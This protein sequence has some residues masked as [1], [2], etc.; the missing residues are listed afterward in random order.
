M[1]ILR[2]PSPPRRLAL[3]VVVALIVAGSQLGMLW[4]ANAYLDAERG[5]DVLSIEAL[6]GLAAILLALLSSRV[7]PRPRLPLPVAQDQVGR[8]LF[9]FLAVCI[10]GQLLRPDRPF[11]HLATF[12]SIGAYYVIGTYVG[13]WFASER[14]TLPVLPILLATYSLWYLGLAVFYAQGDLGFYG[15]LPDSDVLRLE[16]R[17]GFT[18]TE[19]PIYVGFQVPVLLYAL[20]VP[21]GALLTSWALV[22]LACAATLVYLS[23]SSAA[24][25]AFLLVCVV[26]VMARRGASLSSFLRVATVGGAAVAV[27][28][29]VAGGV[30][31]SVGGKLLDFFSNDGVRARIYGEL[32]AI[33]QSQPMGIGKSRFVNQNDFGLSGEGVFP[34]NN[35]LGI[36]AEMGVLAMLLFLA[37]CAAVLV[38]LGRMAWVRRDDIPARVRMLVAIALG[39]FL[40]QQFRGLFQ[41]TWEVK[42]TYFWLGVGAGVGLA[43]ARGRGLSPAVRPAR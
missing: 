39:T 3:A 2:R 17:G 41:D 43:F 30:V 15:I 24:M 19:V 10:A 11:E 32:L 8:W 40:Y 14:A 35:V 29:A 27:L 28:V 18:A 13:R 42:E 20:L 12:V 36:G 7:G 37:L 38:Q 21:N 4:L 31:Q 22:L 16:F 33:I 25:A 5:A 1:T 6:C 34:H 23:A 26:A 9:A